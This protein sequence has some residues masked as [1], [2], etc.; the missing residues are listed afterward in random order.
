MCRK[1]LPQ[2]IDIVYINMPVKIR[3]SAYKMREVIPVDGKITHISA[4]RFQ[5]HNGPEYY[6]AYVDIDSESLKTMPQVKL[7][8]GMPVELLLVN[9]SRTLFE[10]LV[11]PIKAVMFKSFRAD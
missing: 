5:S 7:Q 9:G 11:Y 4:D 6:I 1:I 2:D 10:Y 8:P 3:L